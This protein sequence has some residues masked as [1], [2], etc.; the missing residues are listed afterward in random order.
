MPPNTKHKFV[1]LLNK[2][3]PTGVALN[4]ASHMA[5]CLVGR[6]TESERE[7]MM[8]LDYIDGNNNAHPT[9][10]LSLIVLRA[11]NSNKIR[12]AREAAKQANITCIDFLE[13]MTGDS[14]VE[15]MERTK[16]LKE[17]ELEYYGLCL[18][19]EKEA[20]DGITRKFSL[21]RD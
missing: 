21:W 14:Y 13:S 2:K 4:A 15:Q 10:G 19:G 8:F 16:Q 18:F 12:Q 7:Q 6:A 3:L 9:S 20:L 11:D 17:D 1:V 5:A